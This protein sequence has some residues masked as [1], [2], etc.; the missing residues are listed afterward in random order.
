MGTRFKRNVECCIPKLLLVGNRCD[1]HHF[2]MGA[3]EMV[4]VA[5]SNDLSIA[6]QH[7]SNHRVGT[8]SPDSQQ[9]KLKAAP[10]VVIVIKKWH[11]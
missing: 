1:G 6:D 2:G 8:H 10:H 4:M 3:T 5:L 7:S 9:G 11:C